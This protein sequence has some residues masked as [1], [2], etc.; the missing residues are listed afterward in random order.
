MTYDWMDYNGYLN[1][2]FDRYM[3]RKSYQYLVIYTDETT[4]G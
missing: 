1:N 4:E 2:I 3:L